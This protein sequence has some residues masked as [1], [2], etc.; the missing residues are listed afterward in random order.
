VTVPLTGTG[1]PTAAFGNGIVTSP[2]G[3]SLLVVADGKLLKVDPKTGATTVS[4]LGGE[5]LTNGDG[6]LR[7]G[8][9]LYVVQNRLNAV[10]KFDL[11]RSGS[12]GK[13]VTKATDPRFDVPTTVAPFAGKL[14]LPN[15]RFSSPQ[16]PETTFDVIAIPKF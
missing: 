13:L 7:R 16:T 10:A 11:N 8:S 3:K 1:L 4:D 12:S 2:D 14:Y 9:T 5:E 15:A 6:L